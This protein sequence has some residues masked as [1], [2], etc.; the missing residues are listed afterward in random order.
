MAKQISDHDLTAIEQAV[1]SYPEGASA[2]Q[3]LQ[4]LPPPIPLRT[5]QYRLKHLV[6]HNRLVKQGEGR[7]ARYLLPSSASKS[8]AAGAISQEGDESVVPLSSAGIAIRD[9]VRQ[10][11]EARRPVG[12]DRGFLDA[13]RPNSSFYLSEDERAHLAAV[14]RPQIAEQP[15]GTYAKQI[16]SRLLID[17]AWNSSRLEG[18]TYSLLDTK[19]LIELGEEAEGRAHLEAQMIDHHLSDWPLPDLEFLF[20]ENVGNLVCTTSYDLGESLRVVMLSVTE[21]EDKPLKYPGLFHSADVAL[22]TKVDLADICECD[23]S[24]ARA[25]IESVRPGIPVLTTSARTGAGM[26]EWLQLLQDRRTI[27]REER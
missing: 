6:T 16:L 25:N 26:D 13:Y 27:E 20:I 23:L 22:L 7:W 21:G 19:R 17:L 3:I 5:L 10:P 24:R 8:E 9:Y 14:G 18:N 12:Y 4:A 11:P 1:G 2:Q 15:A